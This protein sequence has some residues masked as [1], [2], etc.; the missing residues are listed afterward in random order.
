MPS[1]SART[2]ATVASAIP[3]ARHVE[4]TGAAHGVAIQCAREVNWLLVEHFQA[5]DR[6][7][8]MASAC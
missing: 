5:A 1:S 3:G 2:S 8:L 4:I 6:P 7:R